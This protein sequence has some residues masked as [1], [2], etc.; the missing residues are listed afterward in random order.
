M[1][2]FKRNPDP[3][4]PLDY[5]RRLSLRLTVGVTLFFLYAPILGLIVFSF[6][7][8]RRNIVW[9]GFTTDYYV[10]LFNNEALMLAFGNSL[11]IALFTTL[12]STV[13]GALTAYVLWRYRFPGKAI[14]E[15]GMALPIVIP[16]ICMGVAM[17]VFFAR[18]GWP[19]GMMWPFNLSAITIAHIAFS[20]PFAAIVI[21]ARLESFNPELAECA[22]DL[23]A[24]EYR[25]FNDV[26]VPHMRPGLIA[27]ALLAFTLSLDDFVIT[28]FTSG[29]DTVTFPVKIYS[30]VR[31][32]VTPE[33]NAASTVLI[34]LT[35]VVTA[36][37]LRMQNRN[38]MLGSAAH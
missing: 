37:A 14:Y 9:R 5:S 15:G 27:G 11:T 21:R 12:F 2:L 34:L 18:I 16:E 30:M 8:S 19:S 13:L 28:F 17:M 32:S 29:P 35:L 6:N 26:V 24:S 25:V 33:V 4:G 1:S 10:K 7:D 22:R 31:F 20:F 38:N 3:M 36:F 23:G